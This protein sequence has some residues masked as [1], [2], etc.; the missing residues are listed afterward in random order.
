M[1][2]SCRCRITNINRREENVSV[3]TT[4]TTTTVTIRTYIQ[5]IHS[6]PFT[7]TTKTHTHTHKLSHT[8]TTRHSLLT[9]SNVYKQSSSTT[10]FWVTLFCCSLVL[11]LSFFLSFSIK[12]TRSF[13]V[14][15][16]RKTH[17]THPNTHKNE[18]G[19]ESFAL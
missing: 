8:Y 12:E 16:S 3:T 17:I 4:T 6:L 7:L 14:T 18:N 2:C 1:L 9:D 13:P 19:N 5:V 15:S 10:F 11:S